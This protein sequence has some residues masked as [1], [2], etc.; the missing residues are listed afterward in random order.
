MEIKFGLEVKIRSNSYVRLF[1][2]KICFHAIINNKKC[3][4]RMLGSQK[5]TQLLPL[6]T[7]H[8]ANCGKSVIFCDTSIV[9]S[10][11]IAPLD[12]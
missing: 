4:K 9:Q 10:Y 7:H 11:L 12:I 6:I 1:L 5:I 2:Y 3:Y 8:M